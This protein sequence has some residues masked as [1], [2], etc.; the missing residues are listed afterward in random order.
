MTPDWAMV[1]IT[2]V[3]VI[4]TIF[5]S[6]AN[7]KSAKVSNEQLKEMQKQ[8][9]ENNR[10]HIEVEFIYVKRSFYGLRFINN[11]NVLAKNVKIKL[12]SDFVDTLEPSM[13]EIL[14]K[15]EG[16]SCIIGAHDL[17]FGT[18]EYLKN[19]RKIAANGEITYYAGGKE[20]E[21]SFSIDLENYMTLFSVN[22]EHED[23]LNIIKKQNSILTELKNSID[24]VS[25]IIKFHNKD[26]ENV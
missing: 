5:I 14:Q 22:S 11:G 16:K 24:N 12:S 15:Q 2:F 23:L 20:Y 1:I 13:K 6:W 18:N 21:E 9:E 19:D 4:A 7:F 26:D 8:F 10:P 3:Y 25:G 17:Y